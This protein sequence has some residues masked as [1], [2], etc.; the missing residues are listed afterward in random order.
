M[1][2]SVRERFWDVLENQKSGVDCSILDV[3]SLLSLIIQIQTVT[4]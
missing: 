3:Q 2:N 4:G 1:I